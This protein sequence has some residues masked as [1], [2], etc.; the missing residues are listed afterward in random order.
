[1]QV[2]EKEKQNKEKLNR[3]GENEKHLKKREE[4]INNKANASEK[5]N[6]LKCDERDK[7]L[8]LKMKERDMAILNMENKLA[9]E[10]KKLVA[11]YLIDK[12]ASIIKRENILQKKTQRH[13]RY[14]RKT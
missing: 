4:E 12:E 5:A 6:K 14:R 7:A 13:G 11:T 10:D 2:N 1:M 8:E 3:I 9:E